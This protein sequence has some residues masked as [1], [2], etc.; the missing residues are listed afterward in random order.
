MRHYRFVIRDMIFIN[1]HQ[2]RV[3]EK[4]MP[5]HFKKPGKGNYQTEK[6]SA[7][8]HAVLSTTVNTLRKIKVLY[9]VSESSEMFTTPLILNEKALI[10]EMLLIRRK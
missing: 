6:N 4:L 5:C 8:L 2:N 10:F 1:R 9:K 3:S 7:K